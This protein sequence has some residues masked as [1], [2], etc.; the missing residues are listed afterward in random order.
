MTTSA[1]PGAYT[2]CFVCRAPARW[3]HAQIFWLACDAHKSFEF[4][5][6]EVCKRT[7]DT[8]VPFTNADRAFAEAEALRVTRTLQT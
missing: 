6:A 7:T 8:W 2:Y 1:A 4:M 3:Q 5:G